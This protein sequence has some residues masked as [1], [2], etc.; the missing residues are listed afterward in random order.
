MFVVIE[1]SAA[2]GDWG[3]RRWLSQSVP[4]YARTG[5]QAV[6]PRIVLD[7]HWGQLERT[8]REWWQRRPK[9][10]LELLGLVLPSSL[11]DLDRLLQSR[12]ADLQQRLDDAEI[13]I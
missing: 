8:C 12:K 13:I 1:T 9:Q 6:V 4:A 11:E 3:F 10:Q 2:H 7:E 5:H